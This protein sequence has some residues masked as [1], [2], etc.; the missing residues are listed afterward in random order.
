METPQNEK[1]K[2]SATAKRQELIRALKYLLFAASAGII[3]TVTFTLLFELAFKSRSGF[4]WPS[5]IV[6]LTLSVIWNFTFNRKYTF[7]SANNVPIAML[8]VLGYYLVFTP[9][10]TWWGDALTNDAGWNAYLTLAFTMVINLVTEF[11]FS[12]F[13]V[14]RK[15][16]NTNALG[17]KENE[18]QKHLVET[19]SEDDENEDNEL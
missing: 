14:F 11:L 7:K 4:Y 18:T 19:T 3:Q 13:V 16:I 1:T 2:L 10:S 8:K 5:Y 12:R 9:L 15:S 6:A 17:Q